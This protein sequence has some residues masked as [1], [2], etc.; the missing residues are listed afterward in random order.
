MP[1]PGIATWPL[2]EVIEISRPCSCRFM[3]AAASRDSVDRGNQIGADQ[4]DD[5]LVV[6]LGQRPPVAGADIVDEDVEPPVAALDVRKRGALRVAVGDVEGG[7]PR[8]C[9][10][11]PRSGHRVCQASPPCGR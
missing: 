9:R 3:I 5:R 1:S 7:R 4:V 8:R 10:R 2:I 11:P 6:E